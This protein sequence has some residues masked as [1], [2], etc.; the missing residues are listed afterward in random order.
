MGEQIKLKTE[1]S[2]LRRSLAEMESNCVFLKR[3][4][5][6]METML[7]N[8]MAEKEDLASQL[9]D[10]Q[11]KLDGMNEEMELLRNVQASYY[12]SL[13]MKKEHQVSEKSNSGASETGLANYEN[14]QMLNQT[15]QQEILQLRAYIDQQQ[16]MIQASSSSE[17]L[18]QDQQLMASLLFERNRVTQLEKDLQNKDQALKSLTMGGEPEPGSSRRD[19]RESSR[20]RHDSASSEVGRIL[21]SPDT[22][23]MLQNER[24]QYD[25]DSSVGERRALSQQ[26][27]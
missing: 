19:S 6:E 27:Q 21:G 23:L 9:V 8:A 2:S 15:K 4:V 12:E 3:Q 7:Q 11:D 13:K 25:L 22:D 20:L 24:L 18:G 26:M 16:N 5:E 14:F 10:T 1:V 17:N